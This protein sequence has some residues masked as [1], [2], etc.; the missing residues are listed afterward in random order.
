MASRRAAASV[1]DEKEFYLD[2]FRGRTLVFAVHHDGAAEGL[3]GI[4][5]VARDLLAN[6]TRVIVILGGTASRGRAGVRALV[7][8]LP[9]STTDAPVL[10]LDGSAVATDTIPAL[11]ERVGLEGRGGDLVVLPRGTDPNRPR[12]HC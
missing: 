4:G 1:F 8:P 7:R 10:T 12:R 5:E 6:D 11:L 3:R 2:E 9:P